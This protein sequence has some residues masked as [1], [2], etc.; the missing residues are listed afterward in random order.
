MEKY[1]WKTNIVEISRL[2][3]EGYSCSQVGKMLGVSRQAVWE[4]MK[5]HK[6][7]IRP[8]KLLSYII[9]NNIKFTLTTNGYY[10]AT[11]INRELLHRYKYTVEIGNI[12]EGYDIH[13]LDNDKQ[14]NSLSNL[15]C[16]SKADHTRKY[17]PHHNQ[18]KNKSTLH[19]YDK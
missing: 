16:L 7:E 6:I 11:T 17:S 3:K 14:N 8:K 2:Y 9:Y 4:K 12:P 1:N 15:E 19:L 10:R 13:H 18:Y 5:N